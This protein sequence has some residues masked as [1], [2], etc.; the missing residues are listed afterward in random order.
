VAL[1]T[2][3]ANAQ[4]AAN[5]QMAKEQQRQGMIKIRSELLKRVSELR[6]QR[7]GLRK[8]IAERLSNQFPSIRVT[9][10]QSADLHEY[11]DVVTEAL[12]GSGVKQGVAAERL[13]QVFLPSELAEV[14]AKDDL[15]TL[16]QR[17]GF[18][19]DRSKKILSTLRTGGVHYTIE[20]VALDDPPASNFS[21]ETLSKNQC[22]CQQANDAPR[23]FPSC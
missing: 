20:T 12:K 21:M 23:S 5:E 8:Q 15:N 10:S 11:Q 1:Q 6:D 2:A 16:M 13:S 22:I 18:D 9:V 4:S 17:S 3:L 19:E 7:F 14:A